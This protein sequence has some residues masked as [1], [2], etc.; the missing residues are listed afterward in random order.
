MPNGGG[1]C[2]LCVGFVVVSDGDGGGG[3]GIELTHQCCSWWQD[4]MGV[5]GSDVAVVGK[6]EENFRRMFGRGI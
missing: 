4:I 2:L 5:V 3:R 6:L 1:A